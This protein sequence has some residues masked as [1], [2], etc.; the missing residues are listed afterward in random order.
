MVSTVRIAKGF[1]GHLLLLL[2]NFSVLVGIIESLELFNLSLP[3][4]NFLVL[5][6]MVVHTFALLTIQLAIQ[7]L[8]I[9]KVRM[10]TV[11]VTYYFQF[12]DQEAIPLQILDPIKSRLGVITLLLVVSG[13]I[14]FYPIFAVFGFL[15]VWGHLAIIALNPALIITYFSIFL[16]WMP[17][18]IFLVGVIIVLS[19][20]A[21]EF[22]HV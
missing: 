12:S 14:A 20:L 10:P 13:G 6:Y 1:S 15:L 11:L 19:I 21:I 18:V 9:I 8:E 5:G 2:V 7:I 22:R 3:F 17:P 4:L 16:N